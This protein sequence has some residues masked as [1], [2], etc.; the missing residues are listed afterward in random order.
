MV[1]QAL[2][3]YKKMY[4]LLTLIEACLNSRPITLMS[5][6]PVDIEALTPGHFPE[7]TAPPEPDLQHIK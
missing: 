1:S 2:L 5:E 3:I 6:S 7:L 4:T